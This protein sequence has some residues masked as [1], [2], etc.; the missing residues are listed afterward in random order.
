MLDQDRVILMTKM[1]S[2]EAGAG[3][4]N[5]E[6]CNYFR[7]DYMGWQVLKSIICATIAFIVV[8]GMYI[9]Y[10]FETF[11]ID[12]YKI[13]LVEFG[14]KVLI[15]YAATVGSYAV[16]SYVVYAIKYSKAHKSIKAYYANL[17]KL[18]NMYRKK[19]GDA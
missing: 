18:A 17:K 2:Y 6:I 4:K 9:F 13:D 1:A 12:I 3:K 11:M 16:L 8:F 7:N 19:Q 14:R 5:V 10:D 15:Y